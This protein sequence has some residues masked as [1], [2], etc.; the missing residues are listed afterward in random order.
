MTVI[1]KPSN[2][3][4]LTDAFVIMHEAKAQVGKIK[5]MRLGQ[6]LMNELP[7]DVYR[8][9]TGSDLDMF[10]IKEDHVAERIFWENLVESIEC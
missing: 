1:G 8:E 6:A 3:I 7:S 4:H 9:I 5:G 2:P 10:Y